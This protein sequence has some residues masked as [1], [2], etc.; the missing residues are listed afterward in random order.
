M[1]HPATREAEIGGLQSEAGLAKSVS[2]YMKTKLKA[3]RTV[4]LAEV[5]E[6]LLSMKL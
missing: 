2:P 3:K 5:V 6:H 4:N 1:Y